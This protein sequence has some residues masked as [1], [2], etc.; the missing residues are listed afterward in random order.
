MGYQSAPRSDLQKEL[1]ASSLAVYN[2]RTSGLED[3]QMR[4]VLALPE[5]G[6]N[7]S[8]LPEELIPSN[9]RRSKEKWGRNLPTR[10]GRLRWDGR[11]T[12]ILTRPYVYWGS[13]I[14]PEQSRVISVCVIHRRRP[15]FSGV[16]RPVWSRRIPWCAA[17]I[18]SPSVRHRKRAGHVAG[19]DVL[20]R[21]RRG[22]RRLR[23]R[24]SGRAKRRAASTAPRRSS[25]PP[26]GVPEGYA[27]TASMPT[28][29][30]CA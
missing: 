18:T 6:M 17:G 11:F 2:H 4:R 16:P 1:R 28:A 23:Q 13:F 15:A 8:D 3:I 12:T 5:Q 22:A 20:V 30:M 7:W 29:R 10:F 19:C 14:H 25:S 26:G 21:L 24:R 27:L 9:I